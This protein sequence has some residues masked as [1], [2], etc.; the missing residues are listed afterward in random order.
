MVKQNQHNKL[1]LN[2]GSRSLAVW[3]EYEAEVGADWTTFSSVSDA[4]SRVLPGPD[5]PGFQNCKDMASQRPSLSG[6][7]DGRGEG[8]GPRRVRHTSARF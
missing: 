2:M 6:R 3:I 5:V 7:Q 4:R 8:R 1:C